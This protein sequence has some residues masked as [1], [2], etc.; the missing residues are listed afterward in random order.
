MQL[1]TYV[2]RETGKFNMFVPIDIE[3][4]IKKND[5]SPSEKSWYLRGYATTRDLDRQDDIVDPAGIDIEH[6][7]QHGYINYEHQQGDFYKVGVPTEGTY[8]DPEVGLYVECKLY[9]DNPHAKIMW[10]LATNIK[11]SGIK[12]KIGFSVE[13]FCL[14]RDAEDPRIMRKLRVTNVAVT[15]NPA[16][17]YAVWEHFAKSFTAGYPM[18]PDTALDAGA[19][20]P[21]SFARSLYNLTWTLKKSNDKEFNETWEK[22]GDYLDAMDRNT[23]ECAILFLQI[24]KGYSRNEAL[25]KLKTFYSKSGKE[26]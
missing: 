17:P 4:S 5:D 16:N 1:E 14:G 3:E 6:F 24:A 2:D 11:K 18:S 15:T 9:K 8:I 21:E 10:D 23:P 13:G 22:I 25:E 26:Q 20:S 12:R 7:L 19:L